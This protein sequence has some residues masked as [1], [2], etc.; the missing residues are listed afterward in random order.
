MLGV[1]RFGGQKG[2]GKLL[3]ESSWCLNL[4]KSLA[5][6]LDLTHKLRKSQTL[7]LNAPCSRPQA[8]GYLASFNI[9]CTQ[10]SIPS[11]T[12]GLQQDVWRVDLP[13]QAADDVHAQPNPLCC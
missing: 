2:L 11:G 12:V 9:A 3:A 8:V 5:A 10:A 6:R 4:Y 13:H 1:R 7:P